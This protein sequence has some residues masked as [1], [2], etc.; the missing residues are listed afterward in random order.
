MPVVPPPP[1]FAPSF[2]PQPPI[3]PPAAALGTAPP[4]IIP[5]ERPRIV[6]GEQY[7]VPAKIEFNDGTTLTGELHSG[8]PLECIAL[9]GQAAIPFNQIKGMEWRIQTNDQGEEER[10]ATVVLINRDTLTV[11]TTT[12]TIHVKT[13]WGQAAVELSQ[14]RSMIMTIEKVKWDDTPLGRALVPDD[15]AKPATQT[16]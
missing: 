4:N 16:K 15:D 1:G 11:S 7:I 2:V 3:I 6:S 10:K 14:V 8:S 13:T 5:A 9:Y 12:P